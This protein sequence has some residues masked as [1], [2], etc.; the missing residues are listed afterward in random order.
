MR[1]NF[2][3]TFS[4]IIYRW[5]MGQRGEKLVKALKGKLEP[6]SLRVHTHTYLLLQASQ[7][8]LVIQE[9]KVRENKDR[10]FGGRYI[11]SIA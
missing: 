10:R 2:T 4:T 7:K 3:R 1:I 6:R 11:R 9:A 5:E 8:H